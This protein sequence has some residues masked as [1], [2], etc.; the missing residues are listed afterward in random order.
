MLFAKTFANFSFNVSHTSFVKT[1]A[2]A[3]IAM[4][5]NRKVSDLL[6]E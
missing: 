4:I 3:K 5:Q 2:M 6:K 1:K